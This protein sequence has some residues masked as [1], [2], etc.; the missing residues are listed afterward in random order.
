MICAR[1]WWSRHRRTDANFGAS[2]GAGD[3][4]GDGAEELIIGIPHASAG[5]VSDAGEFCAYRGPMFGVFIERAHPEPV[6]GDR[7]GESI[8]V[9]D[10]DVDGH[11]DI[12]VSAPGRDDSNNGWTDSG[13]IYVY[14]GPDFVSWSR[15]DGFSDGAEFGGGLAV[16]AVSPSVKHDVLLVGAPGT[17]VNGLSGAGEAYVLLQSG[18]QFKPEVTLVDS[19]A[20]VDDHAGVSLVAADMDGDG[21]QDLAVGVPGKTQK[22]KKGTGNVLWYQG[23]LADGMSETT[24]V[25]APQ[26]EDFAEFGARVGAADVDGDTIADLIVAAPKMSEG[27]FDNGAIYVGTGNDLSNPVRLV[28]ASSEGVAFFGTDMAIADFNGDGNIDIA[29]GEPEATSDSSPLNGEIT[30]WFG[31]SFSSNWVITPGNLAQ[32]PNR[33]GM[34]VTAV[35]SNADGIAEVAGGMPG[36]HAGGQNRSGMVLCVDLSVQLP[37]VRYGPAITGSGGFVPDLFGTGTG[38]MGTAATLDVKDGIGGGRAILFLSMSRA[39]EEVAPGAMGLVDPLTAIALP[40]RLGGGAGVP[41]A[42]TYT[43]SGTYP[44]TSLCDVFYTQVFVADPGSPWGFSST[45]GLQ[46]TVWK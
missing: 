1:S 9:A 20:D 17:T 40:F 38:Q 15:I 11:P 3:L 10:L 6:S 2:S 23:P 8:V 41:G 39:W 44:P 42:G 14:W 16:G 29:G 28:S 18:R 31:P 36:H 46:F 45:N 5:A 33:M 26:K 43:L 19:T 24:V 7:F 25:L 37:F 21:V 12:A 13:A 22:K 34:S 4:D 27:N 35:D 30:V 32:T